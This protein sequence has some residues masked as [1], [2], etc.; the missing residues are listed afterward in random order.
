MAGKEDA[1]KQRQAHN[2]LTWQGLSAYT[3]PF[4]NAWQKL[5]EQSAY[6]SMSILSN[7]R[8]PDGKIASPDEITSV[9]F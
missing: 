7:L 3:I 5:M 8:G 2:L 6:M 4:E 9:R 1:E